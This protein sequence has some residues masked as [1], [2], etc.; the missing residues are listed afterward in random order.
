VAH[1]HDGEL[2]REPV[3][4]GARCH[5]IG[6]PDEGQHRGAQAGRWP[7]VALQT[8]SSPL[9]DVRRSRL[10]TIGAA[11]ITVRGGGGSSQSSALVI[12]PVVVVV[13]V[14]QL[15]HPL[16]RH[17]AHGRRAGGEAWHGSQPHAMP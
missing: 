13:V 6:E 1:H 12:I 5:R 10:S 2:T 17:F 15:R 3:E 8:F 16:V 7:R 9:V 14:A 11:I 4:E